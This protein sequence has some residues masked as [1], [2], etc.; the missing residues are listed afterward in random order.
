[1]TG[2]HIAYHGGGGEAA[3]LSVYSTNYT[4]ASGGGAS[5]EHVNRQLK[6]T[7]GESCIVMTSSTLRSPPVSDILSSCLD[8]FPL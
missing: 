6:E 3:P 5:D 7:T 2:K 4:E 8:C 1:M